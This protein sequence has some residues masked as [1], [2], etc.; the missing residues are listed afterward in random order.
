VLPI[1]AIWLTG[2]EIACRIKRSST[3]QF[4]EASNHPPEQ[5]EAGHESAAEQRCAGPKAALAAVFA[6][7]EGNRG[8]PRS[9]KPRLTGPA[10]VAAANLGAE[11]REEALDGAAA[12]RAMEAVRSA[13]G[14]IAGL[15]GITWAHLRLQSRGWD[16]RVLIVFEWLSRIFEAALQPAASRAFTQESLWRHARI[17]LNKS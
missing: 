5:A 9:R 4:G 10:R 13:V 1:T 14:A 17:C 2:D 16:C 7:T 6:K 15:G 3:G 12:V 8:T 11:D